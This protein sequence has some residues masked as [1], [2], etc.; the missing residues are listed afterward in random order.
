MDGKGE[1]GHPKR[2]KRRRGKAKW[3]TGKGTRGRGGC[4][5]SCCLWLSS[6]S[7]SSSTSPPV[8]TRA[9]CVMIRVLLTIPTIRIMSD[10]FTHLLSELFQLAHDVSFT[11]FFQIPEN[12][13][14]SNSHYLKIIFEDFLIARKDYVRLIQEGLRQ[15]DSGRITSG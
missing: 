15:A 4:A 7:T 10:K 13:L 6:Y 9:N 5:V 14:I 8:I 1:E 3:R 11:S 2:G 12:N